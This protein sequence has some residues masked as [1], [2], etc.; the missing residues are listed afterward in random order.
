MRPRHGSW[1]G[2]IAAMRGLGEEQ[3]R[4][5]ER[6][7]GFLEALEATPMT[8]SYKML[9]LQAMLNEDRFPGEIGIEQLGETVAHLAS[10]N[11]LLRDDLGPGAAQTDGL[12]RLLEKDPIDAWVKGKGMRGTSYFAY[13]GG[14]FRSTLPTQPAERAAFQELTREIVDWRLADYLQ[15]LG[16][17][18][19]S[20]VGFV[21]KVSHSGGKP[22][23]RLPDRKSHPD[24]PT[25]PTPL[26]IDGTTFDADFVKVALNVVRQPG[27]AQN[28]LPGILRGWFGPEA[29]L[30]GTRHEVRLE[31]TE[32]GWMMKP[33]P[34]FHD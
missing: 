33:R 4:A 34:L 25:G 22:I 24:L 31:K 10:R 19:D 15:R 12:R 1:L 3:S 9:V 13:E 20:E 16:R 32:A 6:H 21:C 28:Q 27:N 26:E 29:G 7:R 18:P 30:P 5:F 8:R 17:Q 11:H 14:V 23:L 2:F